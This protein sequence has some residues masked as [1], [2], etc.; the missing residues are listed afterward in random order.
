MKIIADRVFPDEPCWGLCERPR[1]TVMADGSRQRRWV[2]SVYVVRESGNAIAEHNI[3]YGPAEEFAKIPPLLVPSEGVD[4]VAQLQE[5]AERHRHDLRWWS[6]RENLKAESTL[7][8]DIV[9]Q[10]EEMKSAIHNK[11][12][13]G[14]AITIQRN[15]YSHATAMRVLNGRR[16]R[17]W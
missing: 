1:L 8:K 5:L 14:P 3:D 9:R 4:T 17:S 10:D 7:M 16:K 13:I 15:G 6:Y 11:S 2:Q 12:V